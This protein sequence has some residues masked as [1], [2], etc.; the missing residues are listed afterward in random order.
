[1][2]VPPAIAGR[3]FLR[4]QD[5][6]VPVRRVSTVSDRMLR[7]ENKQLSTNTHENHEEKDFGVSSCEFV[8]PIRVAN[9]QVRHHH[10]QHR[11]LPH[12]VL[13]QLQYDSNFCSSRRSKCS[14]RNLWNS[15][16]ASTKIRSRSYPPR[17]KPCVRTTR[18]IA[19]ARTRISFI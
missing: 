13:T 18:I 7:R 19:I 9:S 5:S 10:R 11:L 14:S 2:S 12:A 4:G 1:M 8:V 17:A 6:C 16:A 3:S 15:C